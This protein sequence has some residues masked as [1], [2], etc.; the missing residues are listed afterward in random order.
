MR[1]FGIKYQTKS[2][3]MSTP[4][5]Q[6]FG[7]VWRCLLIS[8]W[9]V[10]LFLLCRWSITR[11]VWYSILDHLWPRSLQL[12]GAAPPWPDRTQIR[13]TAPMTSAAETASQGLVRP[14]MSN[15]K[16]VSSPRMRFGCSGFCSIFAEIVVELHFFRNKML[17]FLIV[18]HLVR[19]AQMCLSRGKVVTQN[20]FV[21]YWSV[22]VDETWMVKLIA[23]QYWWHTPLHQMLDFL[24]TSIHQ[25]LH[26][27]F[28]S[29]ALPSKLFIQVW[30]PLDGVPSC[31][32]KCWSL[33]VG[34]TFC[35]CGVRTPWWHTEALPRLWTVSSSVI[36]RTWFQVKALVFLFSRL[37]VT[38]V[39]WLCC[40]CVLVLLQRDGCL[41]GS[42]WQSG[43]WTGTDCSQVVILEFAHSG[44]CTVLEWN[45]GVKLP[46]WCLL[47]IGIRLL[48][49]KMAGIFL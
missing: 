12:I 15:H 39:G 23:Q 1:S 32:H 28:Q 13:L 14:L 30:F 2:L 46:S 43:G 9:L 3:V 49:G 7:I 16:S 29:R 36:H 22:T 38:S 34:M 24:Q 20:N 11:F 5:S 31:I 4:V 27:R 26:L 40:V 21:L 17:M 10:C 44:H 35:G 18:Q 41:D 45:P 33:P 19:S 42:T 37:R 47:R 25:T 8:I 6:G 48:I